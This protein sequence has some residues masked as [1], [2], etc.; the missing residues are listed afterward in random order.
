VEPIYAAAQKP[1]QRYAP[2]A[3]K[4]AASSASG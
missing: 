3:V 1:P 2:P 4:A